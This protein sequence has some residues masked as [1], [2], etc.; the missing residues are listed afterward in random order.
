MGIIN[1]NKSRGTILIAPAIVCIAWLLFAASCSTDVREQE[2]PYVVTP[3]VIPLSE[4]EQ[5]EVEFRPDTI[6]R[7][8]LKWRTVEPSIPDTIPLQVP[9]RIKH[10]LPNVFR[11]VVRTAYKPGTDGF[12]APREYVLPEPTTV[13][14]DDQL[15][16]GLFAVQHGDT[17]FA[18]E[19]YLVRQ[20]EPVPVQPLYQDRSVP[21]D[22]QRLGPG[23]GLSEGKAYSILKDSHGFLWFGFMGEGISRYDGRFITHYGEGN[24][25]KGTFVRDMIEDRNGN[26][27][28]CTSFGIFQYTGNGFYRIV[29][30]VFCEALSILEASDGRIWFG[31]K[32]GVMVYDGEVWRVYAVEDGFPAGSVTDLL[33]DRDGNIWATANPGFLK[34]TVD[35]VVHIAGNRGPFNQE[36]YSVAEDRSGSLWFGS[37]SG[38][39]RYDHGEIYRYL[40]SNGL[41]HHCNY[42]S[43]LKDQDGNLWFGT[44]GEGLIHFDGEFFT[45]YSPKEGCPDYINAL[46]SEGRNIWI[47]TQGEG[48]Y[49]FR[50]HS[51]RYYHDFRDHESGRILT[52]VS[53]PDGSIMVGTSAKGL[54]RLNSDCL[55]SLS[56]NN[57][58]PSYITFMSERDSGRLWIN[59]KEYITLYEDGTFRVAE[60]IQNTAGSILPTIACIMEDRQGIPWIGTNGGGIK[61]LNGNYLEHLRMHFNYEGG[62]PLS[63]HVITM[64]EDAAGDLW[65]GTAGMSLLR[66]SGSKM[67]HYDHNGRVFKWS[68]SRVCQ[69]S[70]G[71]LWFGTPMNGVSAYDGNSFRMFTDSL[72]LPHKTINALAVD[73]SDNIWIGTP[74]GIS[75]ISSLAENRY[76]IR[77]FT[78][79]D[80]MKTLPVNVGAMCIDQRQRLWWGSGDMLGMLDLDH[81]ELSSSSPDIRLLDL[82]V[83][84]EHVDY[85]AEKTETTQPAG[86]RYTGVHRYVNIPRE[87]VLFHRNNSLTFTYSSIF[88]TAP[89]AVRYQYY[90]DGLEK[91]W[92]EWTRET[93]A[94]YRSIPPGRYTLKIRAAGLGDS[95]SEPLEYAF[96][97]RWPW[98]FTWWSV[99]LYAVILTLLVRYYVRAFQGRERYRSELQMKAFEVEKMQEVDRMKSRF[100]ANISH[101]F[102]T[103]LTLI[104]GPVDQLQNKLKEKD[105]DAARELGIVRRNA[106]RL[107]QLI[108]QLLDISKLE[109]GKVRLEVHEGDLSEFARRLVLSFISRAESRSIRYTHEIPACPEGIWFDGDKMEKILSN[110]LSNAFKYTPEGGEI[111][112]S[113]S[114]SV[115]KKGVP[116]KAVFLVRDSGRGIDPGQI[117]RIFDRFYQVETEDSAII[118]G[119][120][121]GLSLVKE[122]VEVYRG[123]ISVESKPGQGSLFKVILP[124]S[125]KSFSAEEIRMDPVVKDVPGKEEEQTEK[126]PSV[127]AALHDEVRSAPDGADLP[128]ILVVEDNEDLR[129][130]I[131]DHLR[132]SYT[133]ME[134]VNGRAGFEKAVEAIPD[135]IVTDLMM[136]EMDGIEMC[137]R[138]RLDNRIK[139]V[140]IVMLTAKADKESKLQGFEEGA[141]DYL[142]KPFDVDELRVRVRNLIDQR[143][144]LRD[145]YR[146]E[147]IASDPLTLEIPCPDNDFMNRVNA[148][149][150]Q[151]MGDAGFGVEELA[152]EIGFSR[153]QLHRKLCA[154]T[155]YVPSTY[156]RNIR[157]K[158]AVRLFHEGHTNITEVLYTVGF[159]TP[160]HFSKAFRELFGMNPSEYIKENGIK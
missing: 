27:W 36:F 159:N 53:S 146:R 31:L 38:V 74:R 29:I 119:T 61:I 64:L 41:P 101:E 84:Q 150:L 51:V 21:F 57:P 78:S 7:D 22:F 65:F 122:L 66:L 121:I 98:Y 142:I 1:L 100:F 136:P 115:E 86:M 3:P 25:F 154:L 24:G 11:N 151:H 82:H 102:R 135:L 131:W 134:A 15:A 140:P 72:G 148:C 138:I 37:K 79:G 124:V 63:G 76:S 47:A 17:L 55:L 2:A 109:T 39:F 153:S 128:V 88:W 156:M 92:G 56:E 126:D 127:P 18:P 89:H 105:P 155:G 112:F 34:F 113:L 104:L 73:P 59:N 117:D 158:Q 13:K 120:G 19:I 129:K 50:R 96:R 123:E 132:D 107:Y 32:N 91:E 106:S 114:F 144:R 99:L 93:K 143:R 49:R 14:H 5:R 20:P 111:R 152:N 81:V 40:Q 145:T 85:Y 23:Q 157:L 103:P 4:L 77:N 147:F 60:D 80:G 44:Y 71:T 90:L 125:R 160:S 45:Q 28:V 118:E 54:Y 52:L 9:V 67:T 33:E 70:G 116:E 69:E 35:S 133:L 62:I 43:I 108:T 110:L 16:K 12:P 83:N 26:I 87:L 137:R 130:Y 48:V 6:H 10:V 58:V 149:L 30:P 42:R 97:I 68:V 139:H 94:D 141:D 46:E 75:C 8:T 95:I